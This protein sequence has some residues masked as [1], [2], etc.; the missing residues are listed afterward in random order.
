MGNSLVRIAW[1]R[2]LRRRPQWRR[3][4]SPTFEA[5]YYGNAETGEAQWRVPLEWVDVPILEH[6][7]AACNDFHPMDRH[8]LSELLHAENRLPNFIP[9]PWHSP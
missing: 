6:W 3:V 1:R 2:I 5:W 8:P 7:C 9:T 4:W